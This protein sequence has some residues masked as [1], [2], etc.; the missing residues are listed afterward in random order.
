[1]NRR[2]VPT[3][4]AAFHKNNRHTFKYREHNPRQN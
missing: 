1:M 4:Q 2:Y 3:N